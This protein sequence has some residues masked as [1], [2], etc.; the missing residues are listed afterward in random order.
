LLWWF[1]DDAR[2]SK[3]IKN[4]IADA[5]NSIFV[6]SAS[7]WEIIIKSSSGKLKPIDNLEQAVSDCGFIPLPI[8]IDHSI[9]ISTLPRLHQDPF[10]RMILAQS[11]TEN[12]KI[13]TN[14]EMVLKYKVNA[15]KA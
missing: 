6:S 4:I 8:T 7:T 14:D 3:N 11:I 15:I 10:D 12:L 9:A 1:A 5:N 13:I 2:L